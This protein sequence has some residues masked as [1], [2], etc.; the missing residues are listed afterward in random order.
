MEEHETITAYRR[1]V[2]V[3]TLDPVRRQALDRCEECLNNIQWQLGKGLK[4]DKECL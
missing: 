4:Y 2:A 3:Y 1:A